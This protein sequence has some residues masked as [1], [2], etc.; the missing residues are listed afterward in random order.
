MA[1]PSDLLDWVVEDNFVETAK[2]CQKP[3][4]PNITAEQQDQVKKYL[5]L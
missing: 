4:N 5:C 1:I 2:I 3:A